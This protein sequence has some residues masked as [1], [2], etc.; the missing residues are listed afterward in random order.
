MHLVPPGQVSVESVISLSIAKSEGPD[1]SWLR[2]RFIWYYSYCCQ[3][4]KV[5]FI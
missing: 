2:Q 4:P 3:V 5:T 1:A